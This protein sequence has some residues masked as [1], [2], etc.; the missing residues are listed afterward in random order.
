MNIDVVAHNILVFILL[1]NE[2][3]K[4]QTKNYPYKQGK[5]HNDIWLCILLHNI[6]LECHHKKVKSKSTHTHRQGKQKNDVSLLFH[7]VL[8]TIMKQK[9]KLT[10]PLPRNAHT[11]GNIET[12]FTLIWF[13]QNHKFYKIWISHNG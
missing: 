10:T 7:G 13:Q 5:Q 6:F 1:Q 11:N 12:S 9:M 3:I 8:S 4:I 2:N